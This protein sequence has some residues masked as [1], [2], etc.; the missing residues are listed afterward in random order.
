MALSLSLSPIIARYRFEKNSYDKIN[1]RVI[2]ISVNFAFLPLR[3]FGIPAFP[4]I[5][6][7]S[8][9]LVRSRSAATKREHARN[10]L[11]EFFQAAPRSRDLTIRLGAP[12]AT[13]EA[14]PRDRS[15]H[16][17]AA[18]DPIRFDPIADDALVARQLMRVRSRGA[19]NRAR[20]A[21]RARPKGEKTRPAS[22]LF[23]I[24]AMDP[25][26]DSRHHDD[27]VVTMTSTLQVTRNCALGGMRSAI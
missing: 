7:R 10:E 12:R 9:G 6:S 22:A 20:R 3:R 21:K 24:R 27:D 4:W 14:S 11:P 23:P 15:A 13:K 25:R 19:I 26:A 16:R 8:I 1:V 18:R 5:S 17:S 2:P